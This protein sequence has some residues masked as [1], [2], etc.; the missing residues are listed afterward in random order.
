MTFK[1]NQIKASK[2]HFIS[3]VLFFRIGTFQSVAAIPTGKSECVSGPRAK[4]LKIFFSLAGPQCAPRVAILSG[5]T[6]PSSCGAMLSSQDR[7]G[8]PSSNCFTQW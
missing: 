7:L 3:L 5:K 4:C 8:H 2:N 1:Q 6:P